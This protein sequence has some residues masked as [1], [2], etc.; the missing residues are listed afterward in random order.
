MDKNTFWRII[1]AVNSQTDGEDYDG[2]LRLTKDR[3]LNY[4]PEEIADWFSHQRY[5]RDLADT[6]GVFAA[7]C[8]LNEYM[9]SDG[10]ND[11]RMWLISRGRDVYMAALKNPDTLADLPLREN[12]RAELASRWEAYGYAA[13]DAY[14]E[15]R[16]K[17]DIYD[18]MTRRPLTEARKADIRAELEY[19]PHKIPDQDAAK[20]LLPKLFAKYIKPGGEFEFTYRDDEDEAIN[21]LSD[22]PDSLQGIVLRGLENL[23]RN[24][25][26]RA[27]F[28]NMPEPLRDDL[29]GRQ[30]AIAAVLDN[31]VNQIRECASVR[32]T[33]DRPA[34]EAARPKESVL[35]RLAADKAARKAKTAAPKKP[36]PGKRKQ[37]GGER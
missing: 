17:D 19:F 33:E 24:I 37:R 27:A 7:A 35:E 18:M 15:I 36:A 2:I 11:F 25:Q 12:A 28:L 32:T 8:C 3:L 20:R 6:G 23:K 1:D 13:I 4:D 31:A 14:R 21:L 5:Y 26:A 10:F 30:N 22:A 9:S 16:P 29:I 34:A